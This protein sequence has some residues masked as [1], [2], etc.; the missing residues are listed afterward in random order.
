MSELENVDQIEAWA[1]RI[2]SAGL[3]PVAVPLL[4]V[5][6][7]LGFLAGQALLL[8]EPLLVGIATRERLRGATAWLEDPEQAEKLLARLLE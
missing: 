7:S 5:I 1:R 3:T 4:E 6:R 2:E 8:G